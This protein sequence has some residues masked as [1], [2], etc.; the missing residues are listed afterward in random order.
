[1]HGAHL[2]VDHSEKLRRP[3]SRYSPWPP[4]QFSQHFPRSQPHPSLVAP[5]LTALIWKWIND[6]DLPTHC[7]WGKYIATNLPTTIVSRFLRVAQQYTMNSANSATISNSDA[8]P[9]KK[10][11]CLSA[12]S[13]SPKATKLLGKF[14]VSTPQEYPLARSQITSPSPPH[15]HGPAPYCPASLFFSQ[16]VSPPSARLYT[17]PANCLLRRVGESF[18]NQENGRFVVPLTSLYSRS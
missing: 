2:T 11:S 15:H 14:L 1:M 16:A 17:V 3:Y 5:S 18:T 12:F 9:S 10:H 6:R 13:T 7:S 8:V 4:L